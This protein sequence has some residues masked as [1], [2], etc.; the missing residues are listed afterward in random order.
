MEELVE[1]KKGKKT[2]MKINTEKQDFI[3]KG[4]AIPKEGQ[5]RLEDF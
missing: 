1:G 2:R 4:E 3:E 5:M